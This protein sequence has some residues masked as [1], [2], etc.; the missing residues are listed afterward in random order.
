LCSSTIFWP[1]L[2][3]N[4]FLWRCVYTFVNGSEIAESRLLISNY[5]IK[6]R[7]WFSINIVKPSIFF[8][9]I[10]VVLLQLQTYVIHVCFVEKECNNWCTIVMIQQ[11]SMSEKETYIIETH[12]WNSIIRLWHIYILI[13]SIYT[14]QLAGK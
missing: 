6:L 4:F 2:F 11:Y 12:H 7:Y 3:A 9:N 14:F 10:V 8:Q 13:C 1:P 5:K